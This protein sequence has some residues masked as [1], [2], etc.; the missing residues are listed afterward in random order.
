MRNTMQ[1]TKLAL[2]FGA[3]IAVGL[4]GCNKPADEA[5]APPAPATVE[6]PAET[7]PA[8]PMTPAMPTTAA[9]PVGSRAHAAA[10]SRP[11]T[12][13]RVMAASGVSTPASA[14]APNSPTL[15]PATTETSAIDR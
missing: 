15:W 12:P 7:M 6:A 5:A 13:A 2:A 14:A 9:M 4:V 11:R 8:E 10:I 1:K 3:L